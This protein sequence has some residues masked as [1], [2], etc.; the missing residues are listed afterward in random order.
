[1]EQIWNVSN[2]VVMFFRISIFQ[3]QLHENSCVFICLQCFR[4]KLKIPLLLHTNILNFLIIDVVILTV[5]SNLQFNVKNSTWLISVFT[6]I[7]ERVSFF[8][9]TLSHSK[10]TLSCKIGCKLSTNSDIVIF[11][12]VHSNSS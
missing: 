10:N 7:S 2:K 1:M 4:C 11:S 6:N 9:T 3:L 12:L 8:M 5:F